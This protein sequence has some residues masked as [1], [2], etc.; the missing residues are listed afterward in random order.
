MPGTP[1][2]ILSKGTESCWFAGP[3]SAGNGMPFASVIRWCLVPF[4]PRSVGF[5]PIASPPFRPDVRGIHGGSLPIDLPCVVLCLEQGLT[6]LV[7]I[8]QAPAIRS[9]CASGSPH[10]RSPFPS[11]GPPNEYWFSGRTGSLEVPSGLECA[12][13]PQPALPL[14]AAEAGRFDPTSQRERTLGPSNYTM[15]SGD[16][17]TSGFVTTSN[18]RG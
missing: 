3:T 11:E 10:C 14:V 12:D 7:Q 8:S 18:C 13:A 5:G 4:F 6:Q 2:R 9:A 1:S 17:S 15:H 16:L